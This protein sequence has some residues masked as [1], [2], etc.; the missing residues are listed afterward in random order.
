M[1]M[2]AVMIGR[3]D[4][5][6]MTEF[7]ACVSLADLMTRFYDGCIGSSWTFVCASFNVIVKLPIPIPTYILFLLSGTDLSQ[8][9][10]SMGIMLRSFIGVFAW[11]QKCEFRA[12]LCSNIL[13]FL[14]FHFIFIELIV[15][16]ERKG[17]LSNQRN[18]TICLRQN[19]V[20]KGEDR[21]FPM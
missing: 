11:W 18:C 3:M 15:R 1:V 10:D 19:D 5:I 16:P 2:V 7:Q 4:G 9:S 8:N 14:I 12:R 20:N 6:R 13:D 21:P 17:I